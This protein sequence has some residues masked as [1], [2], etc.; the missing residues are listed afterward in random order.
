MR[1]SAALAPFKRP[2]LPFKSVNE[3]ALL[4][5]LTPL[6]IQ[7]AAHIFCGT[8][9]S[10]QSGA[11][12]VKLFYGG[13][14]TPELGKFL[15]LLIDNT[16]VSFPVSGAIRGRGLAN[17]KYRLPS[18]IEDF[19]VSSEWRSEHSEA[20]LAVPVPHLHGPTCLTGFSTQHHLAGVIHNVHP[21]G[22]DYFGR[23]CRALGCEA[24]S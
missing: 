19:Q 22:S 14:T 3:T 7:F 12:T 5:Q 9:V 13:Y 24:H 11:G 6:L 10:L 23:C 17:G 4:I 15:L 2:H 8:D 21:L 18:T 1:P 20:Q 16:H